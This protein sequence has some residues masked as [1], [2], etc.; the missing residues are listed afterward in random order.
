MWRLFVCFFIKNPP[1]PALCK[2]KE[3]ERRNLRRKYSF[4]LTKRDAKHEP[5]Q[6]AFVQPATPRPAGTSRPCFYSSVYFYISHMRCYNYT[7]FY[8]ICQGKF[9]A[10]FSHK[11]ET[12]TVGANCVRPRAFTE[13]HYEYGE[14]FVATAFCRHLTLLFREEQA[15]PL[16]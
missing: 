4:Y 11:T 15:P 6:K 10:Y 14:I 7:F 13:R 16:R 2:G 9:C 12:G 8:T 5:Q 1:F 3:A